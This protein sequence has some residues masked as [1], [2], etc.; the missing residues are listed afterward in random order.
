LTVWIIRK[1]KLTLAEQDSGIRR[2]L[3]SLGLIANHPS[4]NYATALRG[5]AAVSVVAVNAGVD[6]PLLESS[7]ISSIG[8]GVK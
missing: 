6:R 8:G 2:S 3:K 5:V 7:I 4:T 1:A